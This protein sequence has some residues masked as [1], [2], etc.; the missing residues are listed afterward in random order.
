M[1]HLTIDHRSSGSSADSRKCPFC[2]LWLSRVDAARRHAKRCPERGGRA[3]LYRKRGRRTKSC[4]QCSRVKVHCKPHKEG[5]CERCIPRNL[6]CSFDRHDTKDVEPSTPDAISL[7]I[8]HQ[9]HGRIPLSFL[10]NAT[11]D[12]QDYLTERAIGMEP[13]GT[14]LGP[15]FSSRINAC[16][17]YDEIL[18]Y[19]DPSILLLFD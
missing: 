2:S 7:D 9:P 8:G 18:G 14:P 4:D 3:L 17:S 13:D 16:G 5:P 12:Q 10:L 1:S 11:D 15:T 19:L 6:K